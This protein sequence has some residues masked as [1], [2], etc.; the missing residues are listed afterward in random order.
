MAMRI[1]A[2]ATRVRLILG[3]E[4]V[5]GEVWFDNIRVSVRKPPLPPPPAEPP[6]G[7]VFKGHNLPRLRGAMVDP[8]IDEEGLR[9][10]GR[11]WNANVIRWQ[12]V[13][14]APPGQ[15][16]ELDKYDQWLEGELKKLDAVLPLCEQHGL[17]VVIDL[18]S[19]PGGRSVGGYAAANDRLFIDRA[20]Q[21]KFVE[22]WQQ[23]AERYRNAPAVWGYDLVNEP[24]DSQLSPH[25]DDWQDLA[26]RAAKAIRAIDREKAIIVQPANG[27]GPEG[28]AVFRPIDMPNV[29]YSVHMY[30]PHAFT[31][32]GVYAASEPINYPGEIGGERWDKDR[33]E[34]ALA[35]VIEF[36]KNYNVHIFV[37]EFS[38]IRWAPGD[39][40]HRYLSDLIEIF[41]HHGWDWAY[42]AF[43][44]WE[45]WSV[46]HVGDR[47]N[48]ARPAEPT[49]RQKLLQH[50]FGK[51]EKPA[52]PAR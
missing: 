17:L 1:P 36:Q 8:G 47:N 24:D 9:T 26:E 31:H 4:E 39:S 49:D 3:L 41:E 23:I 22:V 11:Q 32:Q 6:T 25:S 21:D 29:V 5:T 40:A 12:L 43:R 13:H 44:E 52:P 14:Y 20:C 15:T 34:K 30:H 33:L 2:D 10:L 46:E 50:W 48:T 28:M 38:A 42:H 7:P 16:L 27:G 51:N 18:H 45:G 35:P 19:P 37:G